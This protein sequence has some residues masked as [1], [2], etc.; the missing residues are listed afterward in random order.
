M[1]ASRVDY[2]NFFRALGT[3]QSVPQ[4]KNETPRDFFLERDR[5]DTWAAR[6]RERL[7]TEG[8]ADEERKVHMDR[9]NPKYILRN[10]LVQ[11]AI[12]AAQRER[13]FGEINRLLELLRRPYDDQPDMERYAAPPP[14]WGKHLVV[15]CSS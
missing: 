2:T 10:Y 12:E 3:F 4:A 1:Q 13:D 6:Y 11:Q 14:N 15:S 9:V 5:F 7:R 8:S